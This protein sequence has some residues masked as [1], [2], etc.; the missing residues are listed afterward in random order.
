MTT[1]VPVQLANGMVIQVEVT[2]AEPLLPGGRAADDFVSGDVS[3]RE[4]LSRVREAVT[5]QLDTVRESIRGIAEWAAETMHDHLP[6]RPDAFEIEFGLKLAVESG[7]LTS[8][9]A[10]AGGEAALVVRMTWNAEGGTT[11]P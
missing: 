9:I 3:T 7:A 11:G 1:T 4:A 6:R 8:V 10:K 5:Y 2:E